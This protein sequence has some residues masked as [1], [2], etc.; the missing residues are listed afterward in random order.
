[1]FIME[2]TLSRRERNR[3]FM[4]VSDISDVA[5]TPVPGGLR[6]NI[7]EN[8]IANHNNAQFNRTKQLSKSWIHEL[9]QWQ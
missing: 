2:N 7:C 3:M 6:N 1:M 4:D 9:F 5:N 8:Y